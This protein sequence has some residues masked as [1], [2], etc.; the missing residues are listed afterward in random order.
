[1]THLHIAPHL[2][3]KVQ[4]PV[5][6]KGYDIL[7]LPGSSGSR[8]LDRVQIRIAP[9]RFAIMLRH[10]ELG[11]WCG[12]VMIQ[13]A[14]WDSLTPKQVQ[15]LRAGSPERITFAGPANAYISWCIHTKRTNRLSIPVSIQ[16]SQ[17]DFWI[18]FS[19]HGEPPIAEAR[20]FY[21]RLVDFEQYIWGEL[22]ES[23]GIR[24]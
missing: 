16:A 3:P 11:H 7:K 18:G 22:H 17:V 23:F 12:Y 8:R 4:Y 15:A 5:V 14:N 6:E 21:D 20:D 13:E 19:S 10:N 1:M 2:I 9:E 24:G